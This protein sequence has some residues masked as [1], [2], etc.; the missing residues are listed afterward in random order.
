MWPV[1]RQP[2]TAAPGL[3]KSNR[4]NLKRRFGRENLAEIKRFSMG[5][6]KESKARFSGSI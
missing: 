3:P 4:I 6:S 5:F 2:P 1:G